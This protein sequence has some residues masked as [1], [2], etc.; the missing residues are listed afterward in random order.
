MIS[1]LLVDDDRLNRKTISAVLSMAD[2]EVRLAE[3]GA[4]AIRMFAQERPAL[5]L[6]DVM[7]PE[8]DG[9]EVCR[10]LRKLDRETPI[11]FLSGLS[12]D[13]SQIKGLEAGADD[14]IPKTAS[15]ELIL[16]RV[17][18]ALERAGRFAATPAPD[19]MTK[20]EADIYRLLKSD[21][22]RF[23]SY[24]EI[25]TAAFGD[26]YVIDEGSI[27]SHLSR[28]RRKLPANEQIES[29][30]GLGFALRR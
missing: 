22:G 15:D 16:A 25:F 26:G 5:V 19:D 21:P 24:R 28:I 13:E 27:R 4:T 6:L 18:R 7:M 11:I 23:F 17:A 10:K 1:I 3:D 14:Y 29:K 20:T 12:T 2:Y 9:F 8:M 30:R